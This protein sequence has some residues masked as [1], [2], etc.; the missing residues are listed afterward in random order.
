VLDALTAAGVEQNTIVLFSSDNGP[1]ST[2]TDK[3]KGRPDTATGESGYGG[4]YSIGSTGGLRGQKRSLF[5]GGVRVPFIVRWPGRAPAGV[6]ND[7]TAFTAVDLLPTLCAAANLSLPASYRGDGE[8]LLAAFNGQPV[9]RTRPIF[10]RWT[11][12]AAEPDWW[13][14]LAVRDGEWKL[15]LTADAQRVALHRV[16]TD[17]AEA[18]DV[19]QANPAIVARLT[20][21]ALDWQATLPA[22]PDP[23]CISA[24]DRAAPA[25][26]RR[27]A[28]TNTAEPAKKAAPD[29]AAAF[30]RMDTNRD[31]VLTLAEYVAGLKD[32]T[33]LE[34]RFKN[35]DRNGDG[36]LTR[37]EFVGASPK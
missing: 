32:A 20:R 1:E 34:Q 15:A 36:K 14:R 37:E 6:K 26:P 7:T 4:Y 29:R 17:R 16:T 12:K 24:A 13:P 33:N 9:Q 5:E 18:A 22:K 8:N 35:F 19:A 28:K 25:T 10:W 31:G 3:G 27:A 11:G 30:A 23:A 2:G 21:L